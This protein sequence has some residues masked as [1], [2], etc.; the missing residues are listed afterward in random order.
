MKLRS[1]A[2]LLA[3]LALSCASE[4][5]NVE[6]STCYDGVTQEQCDAIGTI[7]L[8]STLPPSAG[9]RYADDE[10]AAL[11]GFRIF[12]DS[13]FSANL[14]VRCESCHSTDYFFSDR[15][16]TPTKGLGDGVRNSPTVLNAARY[17]AFMWDGRADSLWSQPLLAFENP[18]EM[19][20]TRLELAHQIGVLYG[21]EYE[22]VFGA[23]PDLSDATRFPARGAPGDEAFDT[24]SEDDQTT[25][26]G[27]AANVGKALEAYMRKL[28][29]GVSPVD[30]YL[31]GDE[32]ALSERQ[33]HGMYVFARSGCTDCHSGPQ[34]SGNQ[35]HNLGVPTPEGRDPDLGN[36]GGVEILAESAFG[37][38]GAFW[39]GPEEAPSDA[40][41]VLGG[42]RT[43]SLRNLPNS[44]PYG[45][46]GMFE[47]L[48]A[49][50]DFHLQG[51]GQ[52][53][54]NFAGTVDPLL[55]SQELSEDDRGAL[56]EFLRALEG[57]YPGLP[58]GQWPSGNG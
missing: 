3:T 23:L 17:T 33:I 58:W 10:S 15:Q 2:G 9:N 35:F 25:V 18:T 38:N 51:G 30:A 5:S 46:N 47:T 54:D 28:S 48:E 22:E 26:N 36:A 49:V 20:F 11:L 16:P 40:E 44:A 57:K 4:G 6:Q 37:K 41:P 50:V 8:P 12:F 31:A 32:A 24:L 55:K 34:L 27:I 56:I 21:K 43:P 42:F 29:T 19:D 13:R 53:D 7:A 14:E 39:D 45:H 52:A 1:S